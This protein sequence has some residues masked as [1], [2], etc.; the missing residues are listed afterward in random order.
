MKRRLALLLL[1]IGSLFVLPANAQQIEEPDTTAI[2]V[3]IP[4]ME[5]EVNLVEEILGVI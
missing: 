3:E 2:N 5:M 1:F 4:P